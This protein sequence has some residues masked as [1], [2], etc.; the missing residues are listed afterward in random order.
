M[1]ITNNTFPTL[2]EIQEHIFTA[3]TCAG[4]WKRGDKRDAMV[5]SEHFV[6]NYAANVQQTNSKKPDEIKVNTTNDSCLL[7]KSGHKTFKCTKYKTSKEKTDKLK[8]INSCIKCANPHKTK[9]CTFRFKNPCSHC[10]GFHFS[11]LCMSNKIKDSIQNRKLSGE[12]QS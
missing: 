1:Y 7:C 6:H 12:V 2:N 9:D 3:I 8:E 4:C 11:F 5:K 10:R